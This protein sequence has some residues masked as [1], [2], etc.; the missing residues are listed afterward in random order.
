MPIRAIAW[1]LK[2][3]FN[4]IMALD[5]Y[6]ESVRRFKQWI[7]LVESLEIPDF[8]DCTKAFRRWFCG[9]AESFRV[10]YSN[11]FTEGK[12]NKIKVLKR[13]AFG[14][15]SFDNFRKRILLAA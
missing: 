2:E 13:N 5:D 9:I 12:N 4:E 6:E 14:F 7:E 15:K 8:D 1:Q 3:M 11:G 10:S